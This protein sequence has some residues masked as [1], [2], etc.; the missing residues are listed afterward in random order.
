MIGIAEGS[1]ERLEFVGLM[2]L[3]DPPRKDLKDL[4]ESLRDL[5]VKVIMITGDSRA[6]ARAISSQV[7]LGDSVCSA[8]EFRKKI[9]ENTFDCNV[10]AGV[11]PEE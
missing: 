9:M 4:I 5:S 2:G 3:Y 7:G 10:V 11:L 1:E 8:D 6:T